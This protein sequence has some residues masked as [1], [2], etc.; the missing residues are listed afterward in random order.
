MLRKLV[1]IAVLAAIAKESTTYLNLAQ[2]VSI[3]A[4]CVFA[5]FKPFAEA[6]VNRLQTIT[7]LVTCLTIFYGVMLNAPQGNVDS[8]DSNERTTKARPSRLCI[9][10]RFRPNCPW[11]LQGTLLAI[12]NVVV[13]VL[14]LVQLWV[15][16]HR[17]LNALPITT[18][19]FIR[20]KLGCSGPGP[21]AHD[22]LEAEGDA[23]VSLY[24]IAPCHVRDPLRCP[25]VAEIFMPGHILRA[26]FIA[27]HLL[28]RFSA[29]GFRVLPQEM[30]H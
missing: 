18:M 17:V 21:A 5:H 20:K 1:L 25:L 22:P 4:L 26:R 27:R 7:L 11:R 14:P 15:S 6:E 16:T 29:V 30:T 28:V 24:D 19:A 9:R 8:G 13:L 2:V 10:M 12:M 23:Q 3:G